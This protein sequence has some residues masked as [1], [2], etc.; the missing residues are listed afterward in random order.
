MPFSH[1][2]YW[3]DSSFICTDRDACAQRAAASGLYPQP[4]ER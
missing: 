4:A 1:L 3:A 2:D